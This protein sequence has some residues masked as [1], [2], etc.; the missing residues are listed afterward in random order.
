[1]DLLHE[2]DDDESVSIDLSD[3]KLNRDASFVGQEQESKEIRQLNARAKGDN[4]RIRFWRVV[5]TGSIL[6][7]AAA[8]SVTTYLSLRKEEEINFETAVSPNYL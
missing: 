2:T 8:V 4:L 6:L 1:M 7:T 3:V 5:V